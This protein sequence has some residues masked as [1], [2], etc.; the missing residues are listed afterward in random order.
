MIV[1]TEMA[2]LL[3]EAAGVPLALAATKPQYAFTLYS[4]ILYATL[5]NWLETAFC[6][7]PLLFHCNMCALRFSLNTH[8]SEL[9]NHCTV[10]VQLYCT[11]SCVFR[12]IAVYFG[13]TLVWWFAVFLWYIAVFFGGWMNWKYWAAQWAVSTLSNEQ[14]DTER[15]KGASYH[16]GV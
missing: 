14:C 1:S 10:T 5:R 4:S 15:T 6:S 12:Y 8:H 2:S 7:L 16:N 11:V 9:N 13:V 3:T